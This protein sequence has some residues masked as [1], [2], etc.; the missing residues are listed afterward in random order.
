MIPTAASG[1]KNRPRHTPLD[2]YESLDS[3]AERGMDPDELRSW[4]GVTLLTGLDGRPCV[5]I[6]DLDEEADD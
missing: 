5:W 2:D 1:G 3:L 4:P 6:E